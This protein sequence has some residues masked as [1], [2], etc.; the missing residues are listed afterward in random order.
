MNYINNRLNAIKSIAKSGCEDSKDY[1]N[2]EGFCDEIAIEIQEIREKILKQLQDEITI[3]PM[4]RI[5]CPK[6]VTNE[7]KS[8]IDRAMAIVKYNMPI[9][10]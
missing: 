7:T 5:S 10:E 1:E 8:A 3:S 2:I 6:V 9:E 4:G